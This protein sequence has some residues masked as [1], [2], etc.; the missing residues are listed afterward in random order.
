MSDSDTAQAIAPAFSGPR[1]SP[2]FSV[3]PEARVGTPAALRFTHRGSVPA[4]SVL[5]RGTA[6]SVRGRPIHGATLT[7]IA[8]WLLSG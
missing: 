7:Q 2:A 4:P 5:T 1:R 6:R 8:A 3:T